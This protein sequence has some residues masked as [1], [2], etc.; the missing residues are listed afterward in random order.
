MSRWKVALL[1]AA[2]A[3]VRV[4]IWI[5]AVVFRARY[6]M[7]LT[8]AS[9]AVRALERGQGDRAALL[10]R[11]LLEL[12]VEFPHDWNYGN[13]VHHGHLVLGRVALAAGDLATAKVEL[14]EAGRTPGSPQLNSFG[15]N[16]RLASDLL[17]LGEREVVL[18]YL[19]LCRAFWKLGGDIMDVWQAEIEADR[20]PH[21]GPNLV[22]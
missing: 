12:A 16:L 10:A 13:A 4:G 15:P 19:E 3:P 1:L 14:L 11:R 22:Y 5:A 8:L 18:Q 17:A 21:F 9:A 2:S 6:P 7:F 20:R